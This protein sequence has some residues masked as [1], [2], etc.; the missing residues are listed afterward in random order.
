ML[1]LLHG[2]ARNCEGAS[3]RDFLR[4]GALTGLGLSLPHMLAARAAERR[5]TRDVSCILVWTLGG[6]SHHDTFD[7][8]P[9]APAAVRGEFGTATTA[10]PGVRFSDIMTRLSRE[11]NRYAVLRSLNPR[12]G[13][14][15]SAD[16]I[17]QSGHRFSTT[18]VH[19]CYGSVVSQHKGFKTRMPPFVQLGSAV[20]K[21]V[22]GGTAGYL[23]VVH[24]PYEI[25]SDPSS[26]RFSAGD[27]VPPAGLDT[28][29]LRRREAV[30]QTLDALQRQ[31]DADPPAF[32]ALDTHYRAALN[33]IAAPET[34]EAFDLGRENAS[35]RDDYGRTRFGQSLLLARRLVEAGV[36]FVTVSD[37]GW[38]THQNNFR[39]LKDTLM[40][41]VDRGLPALLADLQQRGMLDTTLVVWLT[42]FGRT[43]QINP[44]SGRDH[45][46]TAAFAVM[47]GAG[48]PGGSVLGRTDGDGGRP[49][50]AEYFPEDVAATLYAKLGI[51]LDTIFRTP[52]G[53][54]MRMNEGRPIRDWM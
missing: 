3:R 26:E 10:V 7:P 53:R 14:H 32:G 29:R 31:A 51:P 22:G 18:M 8:K 43:P 37:N 42:D 52:D 35:L 15:G 19:P 25:L 49:T 1:R 39:Q 28:G 34:R 2:S 45:W 20:N 4:V 11:L 27:L 46:A 38:D 6:T 21:I 48:I 50:D 17:M 33:L 23:G 54:P 24:N 13:A 47:A 40:P 12:N 36:R 16:Y 5:Q 9:D 44:S 30:F 41:P